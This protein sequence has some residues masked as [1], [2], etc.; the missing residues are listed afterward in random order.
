[1]HENNSKFIYNLYPNMMDKFY[2]GSNEITAHILYN[3]H[4]T[5]LLF[6]HKWQ[7]LKKHALFHDNKNIQSFVLYSLKELYLKNNE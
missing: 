7:L 1:M 5:S 4:T 2:I 3:N 6:D